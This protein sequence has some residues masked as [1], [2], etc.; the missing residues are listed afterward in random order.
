[1]VHRAVIERNTPSPAVDGYGGPGISVWASHIASMPCFA[2]TKPAR[3]VEDGGKDTVIEDFRMMFPI[4]ADVT[5]A[6]RVANITDR[7]AVVKFAGP[8][9]I[10]TIIQ[11]EAHKEAL[12]IKAA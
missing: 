2:S 7:R 6:D 12:L 9:K 11:T 4:T 5:D 10:E 1:M 3:H 8:F